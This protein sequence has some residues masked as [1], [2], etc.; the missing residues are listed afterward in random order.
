MTNKV[1]IKNKLEL[2]LFA[3]KIESVHYVEKHHN[4]IYFFSHPVYS[5]YFSMT[6]VNQEKT[7]PVENNAG[8]SLLIFYYTF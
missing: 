1:L 5:C 7:E 8:T 2:E 6:A 4:V 3:G